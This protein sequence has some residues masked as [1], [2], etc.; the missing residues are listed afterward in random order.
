MDQTSFRSLNKGINEKVTT[1]DSDL[2]FSSLFKYNPDMVLFM[3]TLGIIAKVN[4]GFSE[5][6]GYPASEIELS[7][8][9]RFISPEEIANYKEVFQIALTG[10]TQYV[11]TTF[12]HK[13]GETLNVVLHLIPAKSEDRVIGV[14]GIAKDIT[15]MKNK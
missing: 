2:F 8:L 11:Y 10:K 13:D 3:D 7:P 5:A 6:L 4:D 14:F 12:L 9:E 15:V 1:V